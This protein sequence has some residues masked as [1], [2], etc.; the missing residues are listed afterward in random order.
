VAMARQASDLLTKLVDRGEDALQRVTEAPA[1]HR[2]LETVTTLRARVDEVQK[3]LRGLDALEKRV[4]VLERKV[5]ALSRPARATTAARK[6]AAKKP[7]A[8][9]KTA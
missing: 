9:R 4:D 1:A 3:R 5:E 2:L 8:P 6:P 7:A